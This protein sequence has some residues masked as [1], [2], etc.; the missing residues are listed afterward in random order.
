MPAGCW[1][2][3]RDA[4][5]KD[6]MRSH[7]PKQKPRIGLPYRTV[8]EERDGKREKYEYYIR[9]IRTAGGEPV[10][11]SLLLDTAELKKQAASLDAVVLPGSPADVD[12]AR[13]GA[14]RHQAC[15]DADVDRERTDY[16][17][18]EDAFRGE[19]P[20]LAVCYGVQLLNV[21]L[22]GSLWQD[23][24]SDLHSEI[25]HSKD[26]LLPGARDPIHAAKIDSG[27][28]IAQ[29]AAASGLERS[30]DTFGGLVNTSHHQAIRD[31]GRGLRVAAVAPDGIIEAVEHEPHKHWVVG[32][33]WH[34][35]RMEGDAL[36]AALFSA[37]VQATRATSARR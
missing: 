27:G 2:A 9:A 35:E 30:G 3:Q 5:M 6:S 36:S 31:V 26:G 17:L 12:P 4:R 23:I 11:V 15:A 28:E 37:L 25:R 10:E 18:I 32:V 19:K 34:P 8:R 24:A 20:L 7:E 21:C 13:Y 14:G 29:L 16:A 33:Q 22:G 1:A